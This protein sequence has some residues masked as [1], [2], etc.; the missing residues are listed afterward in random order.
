M[1]PERCF[2][3]EVC[4]LEYS[5]LL[6]HPD[7]LYGLPAYPNQRRCFLMAFVE[8]VFKNK[9][10][11]FGGHTGAE[12]AASEVE[13]IGGIWWNKGSHQATDNVSLKMEHDTDDGMPCEPH[14]KFE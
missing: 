12:Y 8:E 1:R 4:P 6:E 9:G 10:K 7:Y 13:E 2:P 14:E 3:L 5:T 11:W